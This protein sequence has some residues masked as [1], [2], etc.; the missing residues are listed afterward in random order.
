MCHIFYIYMH[1]DILYISVF[2][3]LT[4]PYIEILSIPNDR[5]MNR[6]LF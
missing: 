3:Y 1:S 2:M 4:F 6:I 5:I